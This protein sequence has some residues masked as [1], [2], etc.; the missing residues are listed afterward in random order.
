SIETLKQ[1][2]IEALV[3]ISPNWS[4]S[5]EMM[6]HAS[7]MALRAVLGQQVEKLFYQIYYASKILNTTQKNYIVTKHELLVVVY[8]FENFR[9][10]L[11]C[12]RVV[13]HID[14]VA[15]RYLM[16]KNDAKSRL[17]R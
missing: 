6:C 9:V 14:H 5:F 1:K 7:G 11:L 13:V 8:V 16:A 12:T 15:L 10:Y 17:I 2:L 3:I 4:K